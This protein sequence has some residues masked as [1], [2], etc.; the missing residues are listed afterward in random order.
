MLLIVN[1]IAQ[2][3]TLM[4]FSGLADGWR[5]F[6]KKM[7]TRPKTFICLLLLFVLNIS[8]LYTDGSTTIFLVVHTA[9]VKIIALF[10]F[11][12]G[13]IGIELL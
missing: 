2:L 4:T 12:S 3:I 1:P 7:P 8:V 5:S 6:H 10:I 13:L 9:C 11:F